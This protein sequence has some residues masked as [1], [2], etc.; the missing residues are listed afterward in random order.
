MDLKINWTIKNYENI[1]QMSRSTRYILQCT[2]FETLLSLFIT[3][4][5]FGTRLVHLKWPIR[6]AGSN[7]HSHMAALE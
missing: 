5:S 6:S 4:V 7:I 3:L 1:K 2:D